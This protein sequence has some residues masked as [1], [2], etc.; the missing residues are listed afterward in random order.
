MLC[1][2]TR[3][4][5]IFVLDY[6]AIAYYCLLLRV[7]AIAY[8][9]GFRHCLLLLPTV[10]HDYCYCLLPIAIAYCFCLL[11]LPIVIAYCYCLLLLPIAMAIAMAH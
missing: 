6:I 3:Y 2:I 7:I 9:L 1:Y 5:I 4:N 8:C 11:L 10:K